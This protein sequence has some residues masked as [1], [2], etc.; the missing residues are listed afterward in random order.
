MKKITLFSLTFAMFLGLSSCSKD[1]DNKTSDSTNT[2]TTNTTNTTNSSDN[3]TGNSSQDGSGNQDTINPDLQHLNVGEIAL[4]SATTP[5]EVYAAMG[6][7][8][9]LGNQMD[10]HENGVSNETCWGNPKTTQQ[11][12]N[13]LKDAGIQTVRIPIT[14]MGHIGADPDYKIEDAWLNRVAEIV[15]YAENAGLNAIINIHHDGSNSEYWLDIKNAALSTSKNEQV[16][17]EIKALWQQIAEKFKDKGDFLIFEGFNEIQDGGWGWGANRNDGGKQYNTFNGWLKVFVETVRATGGNN[18]TRWLGIPSYDTDIDLCEHLVLPEDPANKL[19]VA[20]HFYMPYEYTL[21]DQYK[22]WGHTGTN[23]ASYG[24]ENDIQTALK[25]MY[26]RYISKGIPVYIGEFGNIH[27]KTA[28]E[29]EY[30]KYYLEYV[31][32]CMHDNFLA[33]VLWENGLVNSGKECHGYF[34]HAT[35]EYINNAQEMIEVM[36]KAA[37]NNDESYTLDWVYNNSAPSSK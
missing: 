9:N 4:G 18:A 29:E 35:G 12:F 21:E 26:T 22:S 16:T 14:W 36:V 1:S 24:Q 33:P 17:A 10:A 3:S 25:K 11:L 8:W 30:R 27:H 34:N 32:K 23:N 7:G 31:V 2:N 19:L 5:A 13:K 28:K 15:G 20:V 6:L 37:T